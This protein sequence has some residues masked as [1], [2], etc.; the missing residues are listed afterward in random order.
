MNEV[1]IVSTF[2]GEILKVFKTENQAKSWVGEDIYL[3][4]I[5]MHE[6]S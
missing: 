3:Y 4:L 5:E 2:G 6:V 1:W